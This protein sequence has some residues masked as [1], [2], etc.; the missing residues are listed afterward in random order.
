MNSK[1]FL[2]V[3]YFFL[4]G[5][6]SAQY[7][8]TKL[9]E[10]FKISTDNSPSTI[11]QNSPKLFCNGTKRFLTTWKDYREGEATTYAQWYDSLG[12]SVGNNLRILDDDDIAINMD[13]S[14]LSLNEWTGY[15]YPHM[16][17]IT[18]I[19]GKIYYP[20]GSSSFDFNIFQAGLSGCDVD[21]LGMDFKCISMKDGFNV[22]IRIDGA[23]VLNHYDINGNLIR[24]KSLPSNIFNRRSSKFDCDKDLNSNYILCWFNARNI[25]WENLNDSIPIGIYAAIFDSNDSLNTT[26][27]FIK[28]FKTNNNSEFNPWNTPPI[29]CA[30]IANNRWQIFWLEGNPISLNYALI[31]ND[32]NLI[33]SL[34]SISITPFSGE[35]FIHN[36]TIT[37]IKDNKF[38]IYIS[39]ELN[40]QGGWDMFNNY[41]LLFNS[42]GTFIHQNSDTKVLGPGGITSL[43]YPSNFFQINDSTLY[44]VISDEKD[45][46]LKTV[47]NLSSYSNDII[48]INDDTSGSND[49]LPNI[50]PVKDDSFFISWNRET[51]SSGI[52]VN[53]KGNLIGNQVNLES[54][55]CFIL[56]NGNCYNFWLFSGI[57]GCIP[58]THK[59]YT[60]YDKDWDIMLKDTL[61]KFGTGSSQFPNIL[62]L[63]IASMVMYYTDGNRL[64]M[65]LLNNIGEIIKESNFDIGYDQELKLFSVDDTSF[66]IK[67]G[68]KLQYFNRDL[69]QISQIYNLTFDSYLGN[70][71]F[72]QI[73]RPY[74]NWDRYGTILSVTGD[75]LVKSFK[76]VSDVIERY[77]DR[78]F[79][80]YPLT[81]NDF[82]VLYIKNNQLFAKA[83][84]NE[85]KEKSKEFI[86]H[87]NVQSFKKQ[88]T[89]V[90][91]GNKVFFV[92]SDA[93][94]EGSGYDIY[95]S[96]F[97]LSKIVEVEEQKRNDLPEEFA[98]SQNYPNP[99]NPSTTISYQIAASLNPSQGGTLITLKVYDVLGKEVATL[100]NEEQNAGNYNYTFSIDKNKLPSGI[101][102]YQLK[103]GSFVE[104]KKFVVLK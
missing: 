46:F 56:P 88:P 17:D 14:F 29:K 11:I 73:T 72:L 8:P 87:S 85:G 61:V 15:Y 68:D 54:S 12:K 89:V 25:N 81:N 30:S 99:F 76:I 31:N 58:F 44:T 27:V 9:V 49:Q 42:D 3:T 21:C 48:K 67:W 35:R 91:N 78:F 94:N 43:F 55:N 62:K 93:R 20:D 19:D 86:I 41:L 39:T 6:M 4:S 18:Y 79:N 63:S 1:N 90:V 104:T 7:S 26:P 96:I 13:G 5:I 37:P 50:I 34:K 57:S 103:A 32:G 38:C 97:D 83:F 92:W 47:F 59:G 10:D 28:E 60:L 64:F 100:V 2:L 66:F 16:D 82:L 65:R 51:I 74:Y 101:Y 77:L 53:S 69:E 71:K 70:N 23:I 33:D 98:L 40:L 24:K 84:S 52:T 22:I 45:V 75:T 80:I 36:F 95:G 102:F